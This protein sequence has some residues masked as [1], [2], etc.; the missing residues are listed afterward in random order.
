M[1][2]TSF[3][4]PKGIDSEK[5]KIVPGLYFGC[6]WFEASVGRHKLLWKLDVDYAVSWLSLIWFISWV[7]MFLRVL[8]IQKM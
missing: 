4:G 1:L 6:P 5:K 3:F 2:K 8:V 7:Q